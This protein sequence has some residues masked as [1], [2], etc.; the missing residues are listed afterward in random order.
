[1][2]K[3]IDTPPIVSLCLPT[4]G[5]AEWVLPVLDSIFSQGVD[6]SSY[7]VIVA[8]NGND[9]AFQQ[10]MRAYAQAH[11]N[12]IY[13]RNDSYLFY[14]QIEALKLAH[15]EYL[16]FV[17]HRAPFTEGALQKL[18]ESV[19]ANREHKPTLFFSN[20]ELRGDVIRCDSFDGFVASLRRFASWTTGVGIW[21]DEFD[22]IKDHLVID[23]ISPHSCILFSRRHDAEYIIYN[24]EFCREIQTDHSKKGKYD[25]FKAFAVEEPTIT[26]KLYIDGD[27]TADT[28]KKVKKDYGLFLSDLYWQF[29]VKRIP[30]SYD[31]QGLDDAMGIYYN[32]SAIILGAYGRAAIRLI[33]KLL[34]IRS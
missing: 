9:A 28:F 15:G 26:L 5:I 25:L 11:E 1:M 33:R 2:K 7:E 18:I 27:I 6:A 21:K 22:R 13:Q 31:L 8:D 29:C 14:N 23:K 3:T 19:L 10:Q 16:K 17:N 12:L 4:N 20:G 34:G 30:C 32:K 24:Y